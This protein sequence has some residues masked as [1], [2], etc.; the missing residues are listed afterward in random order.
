MT[1]PTRRLL[2]IVAGAAMVCGAGWAVSAH[3]VTRDA[4]VVLSGLAGTALVGGMIMVSVLVIQPWKPR[5]VG[6][7]MNLWMA[8]SVLRLLLIPAV[9]YLLYSAASLHATAL[10]LSVGLTYVLTLFA[11]AVVLALHTKRAL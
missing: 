9:T 8:G 11:E 5:P 6:I 4:A 7:W 2:V 1:W 3:L 10:A